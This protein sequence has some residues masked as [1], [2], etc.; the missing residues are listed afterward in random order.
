MIKHNPEIDAKI[1]IYK[2]CTVIFWGVTNHVTKRFLPQFLLHDINV[3][4]ICDENTTLHNQTIENIPIISPENLKDFVGDGNSVIVQ[5]TTFVSNQKLQEILQQLEVLNVEHLIP[6]IDLEMEYFINYMNTYDKINLDDKFKGSLEQTKIPLSKIDLDLNIYKNNKVYLWFSNDDKEAF[7]ELVDIMNYYKIDICGICELNDINQ[8]LR[9]NFISQDDLL[10]LTSSNN[11]IL[12]Q[13]A[14]QKHDE[15][16]SEIL[17]KAN[18]S[19]YIAYDEA[20]LILNYLKRCQEVFANSHL[21]YE[22]VLRYTKDLDD[23]K[24]DV[25]EY[26]E[27]HKDSDELLFICMKGKTGDFTLNNTFQKHGIHHHNLWHTPE[28]LPKELLEKSNKKIKIITAVREPISLNLSGIYQQISKLNLFIL[29]KLLTPFEQHAVLKNGGDVQYIFDKHVATILELNNQTPMNN[30]IDCFQEHI[31]DITQSPFDKESGF[32]IIKEKNIEVFVYQLERI[33]DIIKPLSDFVG[34]HFDAFERAN[35]SA[36]KWIGSS[37]KQAQKDI[38]F[39]Q[40]FF[41]KCYNEHYVSHFYSKSDIE[42]FKNRW[43]FHIR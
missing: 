43:S 6:F 21:P 18:I 14:T 31:I 27:K 17:S 29:H 2:N 37:Y 15:K 7:F 10:K 40:E 23:M 5:M 22:E 39:P 20:Y 35:I 24:K 36:E 34:T 25:F 13:S 4:A 26:I 8:N 12:I 1:N 11:S 42:K 16:V 3:V 9:Y 19:S 28:N 32:A 30:F 41:D 38:K 33:N